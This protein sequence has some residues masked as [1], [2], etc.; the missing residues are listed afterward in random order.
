MLVTAVGGA[1]LC[2]DARAGA[3]IGGRFWLAYQ[4]YKDPM[5]EREYFVQH[6]EAVLRDR[7]FS[8]NDLRL[9]FYFDNSDNL[10]N[11]LT[12]RR[13]RGHLDLT[14]RY[15]TL[16]MRYAPRQKVSALELQPSLEA[17]R[18]QWSLD[19]HV[20]NTPRL[21]F[22][23]DSRSQYLNDA[24]TVDIDDVRANINYR[25]RLLDL[26]AHRWHT[27]SRS[28]NS[29]TTDVTGAGANA[30]KMFG[31]W[32]S[33][34]AG[35]DFSLSETD[36]AIG[37]KTTTTNNTFTG[38]LS[39]RYRRLMNALAAGSTRYLNTE[40]VT[41]TKNRYDNLNLILS[42]LPTRH[43]RPEV[44]QTYIMTEANGNRVTTNYASLQ[45]LADG[46]VWRR[47]WGRAQVTRRVDIDTQG[48]VLPNHIYQVS[49]R[50]NLYRGIDFRV[51]LNSN[52]SLY[53]LPERFQNSS[54]LELYLLPWRSVLITPYV[55]YL[56]RND[57]I[58]FRGNDQA[59]S[60]LTATWSPRYPRMSLGFD[61]NRSEQTTGQ[62]RV[63]TAGS[64]NLSLYL[65]ERSTFNISYGIRETDRFGG[66]PGSLSGLSRAN[67][68]NVQGQVW[69]TRRGSLSIVYTDVDRDP[70]NNSGQFSATYRQDF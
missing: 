48:G 2:R 69:L 27:E 4:Q 13:Y 11:D 46:E 55:R 24:R 9:T 15:Y 52:E 32:V 65:R 58:T 5:E 61:A 47:T 25:Y 10:E 18:N 44:S 39:W 20:P 60:G 53:D 49:V 17:Y 57:G 26:R 29:L 22:T 7:L 66:G 38:S 21:R 56:N 34:S 62:R 16:G 64:V 30:V 19:I 54:V 43:L 14:H 51:E 70:D 8:Y 6:Y 1:A 33:A 41:E 23:Y 63:D 45:L 28:T 50:S 3:D 31:P 37:P 12:Y 68:L 36:R 59:V 35:W 40:Q 67:T 42:F